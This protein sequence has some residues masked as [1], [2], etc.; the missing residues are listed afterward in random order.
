[1]LLLLLPHIAV[2]YVAVGVGVAVAAVVSLMLWLPF[3]A[4]A[5][6]CL[7]FSLSHMYAV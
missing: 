7:R 6:I 3:D 5:S 1:M 4:G 2:V